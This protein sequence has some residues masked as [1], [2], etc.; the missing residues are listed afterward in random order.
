[1]DNQPDIFPLL[2]ERELA[3]SFCLS[4][5]VK[6]YLIS[7]IDYTKPAYAAGIPGLGAGDGKLIKRKIKNIPAGA[8]P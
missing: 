2:P 3:S 6:D 5:R 8:L 1:V 7:T 4:T